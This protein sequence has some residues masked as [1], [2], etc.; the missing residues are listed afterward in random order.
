VYTAPASDSKS[1]SLIAVQ[2]GPDEFCSQLRRS[3][4]RIGKAPNYYGV[5]SMH[6]KPLCP[7]GATERARLSHFMKPFSCQWL[8]EV[9]NTRQ[10]IYE[11]AIIR[12]CHYRPTLCGSHE[13]IVSMR[14]PFR[15]Q[16]VLS[17]TKRMS[18]ATTASQTPIA[19]SIRRKVR[20]S[21]RYK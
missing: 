2:K 5:V 7:T 19:D 4:P 20:S 10:I 11:S 21:T 14:P 18:S 15:L 12:V 3:R 8:S 9:Q 13:R 6:V 17:I 1:W 16:T